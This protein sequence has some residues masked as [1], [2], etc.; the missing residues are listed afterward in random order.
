MSITN[1]DFETGDLT[2]WTVGDSTSG[3]SCSAET[4]V[5]PDAAYSG[6]Y[7]CYQSTSAADSADNPHCLISQSFSSDFDSISFWYKIGHTDV[8]EGTYVK[9]TLSVLDGDENPY[10][11]PL[12]NIANVEEG[13]WIQISKTKAALIGEGY[14][15][16]T[17][18]TLKVGSWVEVY[19]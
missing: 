3:D 12:V 5:D 17:N 15:F 18:T 7:G 10:D 13:N 1:G 6:T 8:V 2:G 16:D 14:H 4:T 19:E 9:V 11:Y